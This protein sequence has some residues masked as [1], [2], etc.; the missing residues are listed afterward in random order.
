MSI[1]NREHELLLGGLFMI[2]RKS[3]LAS[4][5]SFLALSGQMVLAQYGVPGG[6]Y[7]GGTT[8][9]LAQQAAYNAYADYG[10]AQQAAG[11]EPTPADAAAAA[12]M[13]DGSCSSCGET[14]EDCCLDPCCAAPFG[15]KFGLFGEFMYLRPRNA[16]INYATPFD[17][18]IAPG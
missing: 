13:M 15:C 14:C 5:L 6:P 11:Q 16:D 10:Y 17:G 3:L 4:A 2:T 18:P 1:S 7:G 12:P 9:P 8:P